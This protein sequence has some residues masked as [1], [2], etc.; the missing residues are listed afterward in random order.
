MHSLPPVESKKPPKPLIEILNK[1]GHRNQ[2]A[3]TLPYTPNHVPS[4]PTTAQLDN[5]SLQQL[6]F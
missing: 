2:L 5:A 3:E 4:H 1:T 6:K